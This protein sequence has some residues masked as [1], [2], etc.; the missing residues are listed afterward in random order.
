MSFLKKAFKAFLPYAVVCYIQKKKNFSASLYDE[1]K[2]QSHDL[3]TA[4]YQVPMLERMLKFTN[5]T[6]LEGFKICE[7]GGDGQFGIAR[8][9]SRLSG[10]EVV[11]SSPDPYTTLSDDEL[12]KEGVILKR[13][14][15]E[16]MES[17]DNTFDLIYG[18]AVLE[19]IVHM[20]DFFKSA[21]KRLKPG[22]L[23]IVN[24]CPIWYSATGHHT[25]RKLDN[26]LYSFG[27]PK[28]PV[29]PF[30]HLCLTKEEQYSTLIRKNIPSEHARLICE[31][32]YDSSHINRLSISEICC[33]CVHQPW[34][35]IKVFTD[36]DASS[37]AYKKELAQVGLSESDVQ[38]ATVMIVA[39]K[40]HF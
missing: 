38:R 11:V 3:V 35:E 19:H 20:E 22:G 12:Q 2:K 7:I 37:R 16:S 40:N 17:K 29:K 9:L 23:L 8:L 5:L 28:C 33:A 21:F 31:Q 27:D 34:K 32:I 4:D 13:L 14:P 15:F 30:S 24:G 25:H 39:Q 10:N 1:I 18:C 36:V 26:V 6:T